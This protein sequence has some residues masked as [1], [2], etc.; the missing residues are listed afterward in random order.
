MVVAI[1]KPFVA[2]SQVRIGDQRRHFQRR[3]RC[4]IRFTMVARV[5]REHRRARAE[6]G[7]GFHDRQQ[8]FLLGARAMCLCVKSWYRGTGS[9]PWRVL[10]SE[11]KR[12]HIR[13]TTFPWRAIE[14]RF[15][16]GLLRDFFYGLVGRRCARSAGGQV[17]SP[18][19]SRGT[20][21][22]EPCRW[23]RYT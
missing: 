2:L 5:R 13:C 23:S 7:E 14:F 18:R 8:Q 15:R 6:R 1:G 3:E 12:R 10:D 21:D 17:A 9:G 11:A 20:G 16:I 4:V 19:R 22:V